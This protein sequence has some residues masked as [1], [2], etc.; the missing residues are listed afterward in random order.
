MMWSDRIKTAVLIM[1]AIGISV[2][3][4]IAVYTSWP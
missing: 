3:I 1:G 4:I 2:L